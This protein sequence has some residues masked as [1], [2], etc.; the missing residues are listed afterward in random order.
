MALHKLTEQA[1]TGFIVDG[2]QHR[3]I[4]APAFWEEPPREGQPKPKLH[5]ATGRIEKRDVNTMQWA[6]VCKFVEG[7]RS[8]VNV[9]SQV[10]AALL[11]TVRLG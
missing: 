5:P 2:V 11:G 8:T 10:L 1:I 3:V 4:Y 7:Q 6:T 9:P